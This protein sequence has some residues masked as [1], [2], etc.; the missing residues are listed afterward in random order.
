MHRVAHDGCTLD[1]RLSNS[2]GYGVYHL[3]FTLR[4]RQWLEGW[5]IKLLDYVTR[6]G[7]VVRLEAFTFESLHEL[8]VL[9]MLI[10]LELAFISRD[11]VVFI[12]FRFITNPHHVEASSPTGRAKRCVDTKINTLESEGMCSPSSENSTKRASQ[13]D[14]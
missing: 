6:S 12:D 10:L 14:M 5:E 9:L 3:V 11:V 2:L 1:E 4:L 8:K 7:D 13:F